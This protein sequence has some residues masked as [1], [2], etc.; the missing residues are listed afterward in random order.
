MLESEDF[1]PIFRYLA[2]KE[3]AFA[4]RT[5]S[6]GDSLEKF[7]PDKDAV[8][9]FERLK[10]P[11]ILCSAE[12]IYKVLLGI[13]EAIEDNSAAIREQTEALK[14]SEVRRPR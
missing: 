14:T 9:H 2:H 11:T 7:P 6:Q 12:A 13:Q 5:E 8:A 1:G 10:D 4:R 3:Q